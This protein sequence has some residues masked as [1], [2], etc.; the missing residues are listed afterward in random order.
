PIGC[1]MT[2]ALAKPSSSARLRN[3]CSPSTSVRAPAWIW[4]IPIPNSGPPVERSI[5]P[6]LLRFRRVAVSSRRGP[7]VQ[8]RPRWPGGGGRVDLIVRN[9]R[10]HPTLERGGALFD[11][12][13]EGGRIGTVAE[14]GSLV[15]GDGARELDAAGGL[16]SPPFAD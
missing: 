9:A 6:P 5:A 3:R 8:S 7:D 12:G 10:I 14:A 2:Q 11:V 13:V 16:V 4:G 15:T 1:S